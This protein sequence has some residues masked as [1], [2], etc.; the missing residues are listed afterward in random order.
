MSDLN[1]LSKLP[2]YQWPSPFHPGTNI[3][4]AWD[5]TSLGW[6][7][8]CPRKYFY[9]MIEGWRGK[10]ESVHLTFGIHYHKALEDYDKYRASANLTHQEALENT[11]SDLLEATWIYDEPDPGHPNHQSGRPWDSGHNLKTR[12]NLVR[13]VIWYLEQFGDNDPATTVQLHDRTPAVELS[14]R[15]PVDDDLVLCG[16]LDRVVEYQGQN[17]VMDRKTSTSTISSYYFDQY[18]PDNQMSLYTLAG[19][20]IYRNPVRGVIIDAVQIAVGFSRFERGMVYRTEGQSEEWLSDTKIWVAQAQVYADKNH[21]P[22]N[23]KSCH[24]YGGCP[25]RGICATDAR[26]RTNFLESHFIKHPWN[27]LEVR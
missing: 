7:K 10:G 15:F 22:Q 12:E 23:D 16:H 11:V 2:D 24:K 3:Q 5:S 1:T 27:P 20:I 4:Y 18:S 14:F 21:W 13:S 8:E 19:S 9:H 6:L 17:Y 26:V 25:F